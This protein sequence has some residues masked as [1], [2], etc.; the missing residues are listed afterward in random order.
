MSAKSNEHETM[1]PITEVSG[2]EAMDKLNRLRSSIGSG[3]IGRRDF[4]ATAIALG[5]STTAASSVFNKAWAA[6]KKGGRLRTGITGGATGDVLDPGLILDSYMINVLFGQVRN[7]L[8]EVSTTG[9]LIPELAES[10]DSTPDASTW[11]FKVRQ[12]VEFHNGKTLDS[13]DVVDSLRHHLADDSKSAA[14]GLLGGI[15]SVDADGKHGVTVTLTGGD[16]DFPFLMSD[17]HL[18]I[19]PSRGD[20]TIDWE[21]GTGTGGYTL[22][23]HDPGVRS[24]TRRNPNYW[25]DGR[26]HFDEVE[27]LQIADPNAR[28]NALR[29]NAVDS[30]NNVDPKIVERLKRV[31]GVHVRSVTGNKQL[32]LPMRTDTAPFDNN[33]V[34]LAV[35]NVINREEWFDKIIFGD[36]EIG[37]DNPVGPANIYRA[38]TDELPQRIYDPDKA[39][40]HLKQA[41]MENLSIQF[42]AAET[43]FSGAVNAGQLMQESA[44]P[45]GIDIEVV[46][47]PDDGY[48]SNVWMNKAF[49]ACYWS[50]RPTENWIFSQIYAADA[51]WNDT[52]WKHPRF[53]ELLVQARAELDTAKRRELYVE[54]Q[55]IV[56]NE[57]G[58]CLPLFQADTMAHGDKVFVPEVIGNNW[59]LDGLKH[60]ER[61]WFA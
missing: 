38:T 27:T 11:T 32:T 35:K 10:W 28:L 18:L 41:G 44:R 58:V 61:W 54:M 16:A 26:A 7:N 6:A 45:A 49:S 25:K 22:V 55:R 19:C 34:R 12:G 39:K 57:G 4:M 47:E 52:F 15:E 3:K 60:A 37:N 17:Y 42:H 24:L 31:P 48:W 2:R 50:G 30:I 46:R 51:S 21:S 33:D 23:E 36:G 43:A 29:T 13:Q 53:N 8:T 20:G 5:L 40:F 9:E 56:H 59:D 1:D 14:K